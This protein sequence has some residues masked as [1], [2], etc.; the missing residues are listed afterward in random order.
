MNRRVF[1][2]VAVVALLAGLLAAAVPAS[3]QAPSDVSPMPANPEKI[4]QLL[5]RQGTLS[6]NATPEEKDAAVLAYLQLKSKGGGPDRNYNP[7]ARKL[8]DHNEEMLNGAPSAAIRGRKLGNTV[9]VAPSSPQFKPLQGEGKLLL[10]AVDFSN[11]PFIWTPKDQQPRTAAG[12]LHNEI[13]TPDNSFDLW[14]PD[15]SVQHYEDMIF[16]PGGWTMPAGTPYY[17]GQHRGSMRDYFL[18]QSLG[19]Y[20]VDGKAYGWFT[21][22]KPEAYYGDDNPAGGNDNLAPGNTATLIKDA[23]DKINEHPRDPVGRV[24]HERR[25]HHRPPAL[26]P[27]RHRP[28]GRRGRAGR[29]RDLGA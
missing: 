26:H 10:I 18:Q 19:Q 20:T 22:D 13:P 11:A 15:F 3:A 14:V 24:R 8:V 7:M 6:V 16:T 28:V 23:V 5:I 1:A 27:C 29:R 21:V 25:L 9:E 12:P 17:A 2:V 4:E